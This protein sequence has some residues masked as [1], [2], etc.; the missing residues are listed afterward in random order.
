MLTEL[1]DFMIIE[2]VRIAELFVL[3]PLSK[4]GQ[5]A[6]TFS[7]SG[8]PCFVSSS[9]IGPALCLLSPLLY[10]PRRKQTAIAASSSPASAKARFLAILG[11][12]PYFVAGKS[13]GFLPVFELP[14]EFS[15]PVSRISFG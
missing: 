9:F 15:S 7:P 11:V 1:N 5:V 13:S 10:L 3:R 14:V 8:K 2:T 4:T 12:E 6:L